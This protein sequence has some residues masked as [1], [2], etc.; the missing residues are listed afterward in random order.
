V[1]GTAAMLMAAAGGA[2][3]LVM[4]YVI[5]DIVL[6]YILQVIGSFFAPG[7]LVAAVAAGITIYVVKGDD[8]VR[9]WI[10][11][12]IFERVKAKLDDAETRR[13]VGASLRSACES[14]FAAVA[15]TF[16]MRAQEVL[17]EVRYQQRLA[18][19]E[20]AEHQRRAGAGPEPM[21][22]ELARLEV[23]AA[24]AEAQLARLEAEVGP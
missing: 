15:D 24:E 1:M 9:T 6:Y 4:G 13:R 16:H 12:S 20:L 10:Q 17:H 21:R 2:V 23:M 18:E 3:A 22:A 5:A 8:W 19:E 14:I 11:D 7:L